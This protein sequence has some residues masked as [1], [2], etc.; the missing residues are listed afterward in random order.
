MST[1]VKASTTRHN[2]ILSSHS[3][4]RNTYA[5]LGLSVLVSALTASLSVAYRLP[6][7]GMLF[8]LI[9]FYGLLYGIQ[10]NSHRA[11]GILFVFALT[12]FMGYTLGPLLSMLLKTAAGT[13]I[14][15]SALMGTGVS[16][17][18]LSAYVLVTGKDFGFMQGFLFTGL[19]G[20]LVASGVSMLFHIPMLGL[21]ISC[22]M[23][24][25]S[26]GM[27]LFHTSEII[28][29]GE[30]NYILA[31]VSLFVT[32]YNLFVNLVYILMAFSGSRD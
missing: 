12:G 4:L 11:I 7:P 9:G 32:L 26:S 2:V 31:T 3:V 14:L 18:T 21:L 10:K 22:A 13:S 25:I 20:C 19:I 28:H 8:T 29:G 16:F 5:L 30:R 15:I 24:A 23:T 1:F 17:I 6:A 27:I